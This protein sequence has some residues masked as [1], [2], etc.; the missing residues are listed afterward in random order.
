[1]LV[2]TLK[3][4]GKLHMENGCDLPNGAELG[5]DPTALQEADMRPVESTSVSEP[6]LREALRRANLSNFCAEFPLKG[7]GLHLAMVVDMLNERLQQG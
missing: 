5:I 7:V 4:F 6:L 2:H 3:Q 1:M